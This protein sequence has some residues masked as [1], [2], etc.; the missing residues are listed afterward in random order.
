MATDKSEPRVGLI[1]KIGLAAVVTLI[2]VRAALSSYFDFA[3]QAEELRKF[4]EIKPT[5]LLS[6]RA[7]DKER[8]NAGAMPIDKAMEQLARQGRKSAAPDFAPIASKDMSALHGWVKMPAEVPTAMEIASEADSG[9]PTD[10]G[11]ESAASSLS[12]GPGRAQS[13][14][15]GAP[16]TK[17]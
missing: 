13:V 9:A 1:L 10:G 17:P 15:A 3:V 4:G 11:A 8:L 12:A 5:G 14:D 2:G 7:Q 16:K 6:L